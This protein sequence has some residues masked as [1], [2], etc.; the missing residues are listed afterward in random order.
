MDNQAKEI[1]EDMKNQIEKEGNTMVNDGIDEESMGKYMEQL[2][3]IIDDRIH[4]ECGLTYDECNCDYT[5]EEDY[6][7]YD[8]D[9]IVYDSPVNETGCRGYDECRCGHDPDADHTCCSGNNHDDDDF[10]PSKHYKLQ[11]IAGTVIGEKLTISDSLV[12]EAYKNDISE[13]FK[14]RDYLTNLISILVSKLM[15]DSEEHIALCEEIYTSQL[16]YLVDTIGLKVTY[17]DDTSGVF[18]DIQIL[19]LSVCMDSLSFINNLI[20]DILDVT[21]RTSN[22]HPVVDGT[23]I[24]LLSENGI[25]Y[26]YD[27]LTDE[28]TEISSMPMK[29][30]DDNI[31]DNK[32][33]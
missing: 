17:M 20:G 23:N 16:N 32:E 25:S 12:I 10:D 5:T 9:D 8:D 14:T 22:A 27:T 7:N 21:I 33:N 24:Y 1:L 4:D 31:D 26:K 19:A 6:P 30:S 13:I 29:P 28:Y 2:N 15:D 3:E 11:L 18:D